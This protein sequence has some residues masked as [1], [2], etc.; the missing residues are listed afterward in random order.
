VAAA[1]E[2]QSSKGQLLEMNALM[3]LSRFLSSD[4]KQ[5]GCM[6]KT[7]H[8]RSTFIQFLSATTGSFDNTFS[9]QFLL[10]QFES[11]FSVLPQ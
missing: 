7:Y 1:S 4:G 5:P 3:D 9:V 10:S 8:N 2:W 11:V 6:L